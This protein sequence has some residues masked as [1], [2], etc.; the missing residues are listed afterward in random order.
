M[1]ALFL[2]P[3]LLAVVL[4]LSAQGL[5]DTPLSLTNTK[6]VT[7]E[8]QSPLSGVLDFSFAAG[9]WQSELATAAGFDPDRNPSNSVRLFRLGYT[10]L[11]AGG[12]GFSA[13][14]LREEETGWAVQARGIYRLEPGQPRPVGEGGLQLSA[15]VS[16]VKNPLYADTPSLLFS[17]GGYWGHTLRSYLS[18][19][20]DGFFFIP[21]TPGFALADNSRFR[22]EG[23]LRLGPLGGYM[24]F[25][26]VNRQLSSAAPE[27]IR[28][29]AFK[30]GLVVFSASSWKLQLGGGLQQQALLAGGGSANTLQSYRN[31][32]FSE[33]GFSGRYRD[34]GGRLI[35]YSWGVQLFVR[36]EAWGAGGIKLWEANL[37]E[38]SFHFSSSLAL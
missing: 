3:A 14:V 31:A 7:P 38:L 16:L 12:L 35:T 24:G 2:V 18:L 9:S 15:G 26:L 22:L 34:S 27:N 10:R 25:D 20:V 17:W 33:L 29:I 13:S 23:Q 1:R 32:F 5:F 21:W 6:P 8:R 36:Q 30:A 28:V 37:G 11:F 19:D 4:P